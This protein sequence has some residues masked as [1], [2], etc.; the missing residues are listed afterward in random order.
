MTKPSSGTIAHHHTRKKS[1][2]KYNWGIELD[3]YPNFS[4]HKLKLKWS[5]TKFDSRQTLT[6][7]PNSSTPTVTPTSTNSPT[8]GGS[9]S[10]PSSC[11][12]LSTHQPFHSQLWYLTPL[13]ERLSTRPI[14]TR[15]RAFP[16]TS[17]SRTTNG[18]ASIP[19][20]PIPL[21]PP[22]LTPQVPVQIPITGLPPISNLHPQP[23]NP[24]PPTP[25]VCA[26][27]A[28]T[29]V[30]VIPS[31]QEHPQCP[32]VFLSGTQSTVINL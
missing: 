14:L 4:C 28:L 29:F 23:R 15:F 32:L 11:S 16:T 22:V 10:T 21:D 5:S 26:F 17:T 24:D 19:P 18:T 2:H 20:Q 7:I 8:L 27:V 31:H 9:P 25:P 3:F 12:L 6:M 1:I 13:E 30:I